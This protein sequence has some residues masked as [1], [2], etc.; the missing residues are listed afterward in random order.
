M[1]KILKRVVLAGFAAVTG[2]VTSAAQAA[3]VD[4]TSL[5]AAVDFSTVIIAILAVAAIMVGVYVAWKAAKMV[6][7]AV[8]GL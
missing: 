2:F 5:T 4:V 1:F 8:K 3:P 7:G 6:I